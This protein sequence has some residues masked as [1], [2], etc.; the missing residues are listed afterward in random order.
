MPLNFKHASTVWSRRIL[1]IGVLVVSLV[2]ATAYAREGDAGPLHSIQSVTAGASTPLKTLGA[3]VDAGATSVRENTEDLT[4]DADTLNAL[5][6]QNQALRESASRAEEYR[7]EAERLQKLLDIKQDSNVDGIGGRVIGKSAQAW[8]QTITIDVG[9]S[10]GVQNGMTVMGGSGVIGQVISTTENTSE[11]RLLTDPR[12]GVAVTIQ[13]NRGS[14][15]VR[16]SLEGL[17]YLEDVSEDNIPKAG[18]VVV[19]SGL[20]GSYT[21]GL[22]VGTVTSVDQNTNDSTS[23]I[24]IASN[25]SANSLEEVFVVTGTSGSDSNGGQ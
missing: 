15:I 2:L 3:S 12:S 20:G 18:D 1:V 16:G 24:V 4:A 6:D 22:M 14:G 10:K 21:A 13:S 8:S 19:T 9:S 23:R 7:Q 5:R 11:V 17:L 25:G